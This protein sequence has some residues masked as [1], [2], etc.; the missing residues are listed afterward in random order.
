MPV[1][2]LVSLNCEKSRS[3][4]GSFLVITPVLTI[5]K[6]QRVIHHHHIIGWSKISYLVNY[7][8]LGI[9]NSYFLFIM[10]IFSSYKK[11]PE[12]FGDICNLT[13]RTEQ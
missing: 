3:S 6:P 13:E 5:K 2:T 7:E 12:S 11:V 10:N 8:N 9:K 4:L 1:L